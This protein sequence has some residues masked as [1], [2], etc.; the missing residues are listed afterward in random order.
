MAQF[1]TP[2]AAPMAAP[3]A[4][5]LTTTE[6]F[7][8]SSSNN[9][10]TI[11]TIGTRKTTNDCI[12]APPTNACDD[13][14]EEF[15]VDECD[16]FSNPFVTPIQSCSSTLH[17]LKSGDFHLCKGSMCPASY[18]DRERQ[19]ICGIS[20][21]VVGCEAQKE[22]S[23]AWTGRSVGSNNPD[24]ISGNLNAVFVKR[25]DVFAASVAAHRSAT[26]I[27]IDEVKDYRSAISMSKRKDKRKRKLA[28]LLKDAAAR[29]LSDPEDDPNND[30]DGSDD[31]DTDD[32]G[33]LVGEYYHDDATGNTSIAD[34]SNNT[35]NPCNNNNTY[36][37]GG[38][39]TRDGDGDDG[40]DDDTEED[41][42]DND[43]GGGDDAMAENKYG[44]RS[45]RCNDGDNFSKKRATRKRKKTA[46]TTT[47]TTRALT[48]GGASSSSS[49]ASSSATAA[50]PDR[51]NNQ[52]DEEDE[53]D[54]GASRGARCVNKKHEQQLIERAIQRK[55]FLKVE[56]IASNV[57][58]LSVDAVNIIDKLLT[59]DVESY[60][61]LVTTATR[62]RGTAA[63]ADRDADAKGEIGHATVDF[64]TVFC[65]ALTTYV[66]S[67]VEA[68]V[69]VTID[70][71]HNIHIAVTAFIRRQ[72]AHMK[73]KQEVNLQK[74]RLALLLNGQIKS[75]LAKIITASW[76]ACSHTNYLR[77]AKKTP[78][79]FKSFVAGLVYALKR[80][81]VLPDGT[82][83]LPKCDVLAMF[84]RHS[85]AN[86]TTNNTIHTHNDIHGNSS[87]SAAT[88]T[89]AVCNGPPEHAKK[90]LQSLSHRG[91]CSFQ[92]C[93]ASIA[94]S[95]E[96]KQHLI[97]RD[98]S[99][100]EELS[101]T[102]LNLLSANA[103]LFTFD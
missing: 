54:E 24:E 31:Y 46:A 17:R 2:V 41:A 22:D 77:S 78:E 10:N 4:P 74:T 42:T 101:Q 48:T 63:D 68:A 90:N 20:G 29:S 75:L 32:G 40:D 23:A 82:Q 98:F 72:H 37:S 36:K 51:G 34:P 15:E 21:I 49:A 64:K 43:D 91:M 45:V 97:R 79:S 89:M 96:D 18:V 56:S 84:L 66:Q 9:N 61:N 44:G 30:D 71:L 6:S 99:T 67:C 16:I 57:E 26:T 50:K 103:H 100:A 83:I 27:E 52:E 93:V 92:R 69:P 19:I 33:G 80:G 86:N 47:R 12:S 76:S 35:V 25:R 28:N 55:R 59:F 95:P 65:A 7:K 85:N 73:A 13:D 81:I 87:S 94:D 102:L 39:G 88:M 1:V 62:K 38:G 70:N 3:S 14:I 60:V 11:G 8:N 53:E 58:K 5:F